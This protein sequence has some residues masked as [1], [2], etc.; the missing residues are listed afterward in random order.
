MIQVKKFSSN[1]L[2]KL[3]LIFRL[4]IYSSFKQELEHRSHFI[5]I[6]NSV[7]LVSRL[8]CRFQYQDIFLFY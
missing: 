6:Q 5:Y 3:S 7:F 4:Q 8:N 1:K 2:H